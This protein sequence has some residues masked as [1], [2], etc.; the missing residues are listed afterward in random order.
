MVYR[1]LTANTPARTLIIS[2]PV[3]CNIDEYLLEFDTS[4]VRF[5]SFK[6]LKPEA[7]AQSDT[8]V[9]I[10]NGLTAWM[11]NMGWED[12]PE[13]VQR[14]DSTRVLLEQRGGIEWYGLNKTDLMRRLQ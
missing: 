1:H 8:V 12:M 13:W 2:N 5:V 14:L 9:L 10:L 7:V 4:R 6:T 3:E 11:S